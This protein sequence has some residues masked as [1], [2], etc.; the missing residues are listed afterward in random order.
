V[1]AVVRSEVLKLRTTRRT[2]GVAVGMVALVCF[3]VLLH[4]SVLPLKMATHDDEMHVFGWGQL[5]AL[6]AGLL[7]ALSITGE[8]RHGTIRPTFLAVPRRSR[9]LAGKVVAAAVAGV[10]LGVLAEGLTFAIGSAA[11]AARGIPVRLDGGDF[12]QLLVG[13]VAAAALWAPLGVGLGALLR[14]QVATVVGLCAWLLFVENL[15]IGQLPGAGRYLPGAV[16][17][18]IGGG[19]TIT[20]EVPSSPALLAPVLGAVLLAGYAGAAMAAG[21]VATERRDVP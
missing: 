20:G 12:A 14:N 21:M 8:L 1:S 16:A 9:V 18:A 10:A 6:F 15:V 2:V 19:S 11:L 17:A 3:V 5:G 4:G 13:G 7:G